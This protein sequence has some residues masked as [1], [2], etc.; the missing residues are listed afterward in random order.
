MPDRRPYGTGSVTQ[1]P[2]GTWQA[3]LELPR[4]ADGRRHA[5]VVTGRTRAEAVRKLEAAKRAVV[6]DR[7]QPATQRLGDYL[8]GWL[9]DQEGH[10]TPST[11]QRYEYTVR[12]IVSALGT[13]PLGDLKAG[14]LRALYRELMRSYAG[15]TVLKVHR[16]IHQALRDAVNEEV[17]PRNVADL[18]RPPTYVKPERRALTE[19]EA[20]AFI[21]A[22]RQDRYYVLWL[23]AI[24]TGMR[25]G[26]LLG[27]RWSDIDW[28]R[29]LLTVRHQEQQLRTGWVGGEPK[30]AAGKRILP[31][32]P[33]LIELLREH[34]KQSST[35]LVFT[36]TA[37]TLIGPSNLLRR[38]WRPLLER[39]GIPYVQPHALK[40]SAVSLL[41]AAGVPPH[42]VQ[43]IAGHADPS[44]TMGVYAHAQDSDTA[45]ALTT[46]DQ[47]LHGKPAAKD[48]S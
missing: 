37:G 28:R 47:R 32:P 16:L 6:T 26:E 27:L 44:V 15:S 17:L 22:A 35:E 39:A 42:V 25:R 41:L 46:L 14:D 45:A 1:R 4:G 34:R 7:A 33:T 31:L 18:V 3:R 24:G 9:R 20:H 10:L 13:V 19:D 36:S 38:H 40:H 11:Y 48:G 2:N 8:D 5:K 21:E 29:G 43:R 23:L 12:Q 30:S